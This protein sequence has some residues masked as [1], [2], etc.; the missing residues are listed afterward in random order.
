MSSVSHSPDNRPVSVSRATPPVTTSGMLG[1]MA[2]S[3]GVPLA[4]P[5]PFLLTGVCAAALFGLLLPWIAPEAVQAPDFP[6]V[7]ALVHLATLGWLTMTIMGASLQLTPV[8]TVTPL[9][10][11]RFIRWQYPLYVSGVIL[12]LC[13]FWWMQP[14][15]MAAGGSLVVL[16]VVH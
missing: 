16:A 2:G 7:L 4:V 12:L 14:W 15:L 6:H 11:A 3:R 13:G 1:G 5:L 10:A 8:I 9:R